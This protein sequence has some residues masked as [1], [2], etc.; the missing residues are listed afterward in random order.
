VFFAKWDNLVLHNYEVLFAKEKDIGYVTK[1]LT[2]L[3]NLK[4]F[5]ASVKINERK[6]G[7]MSIDFAGNTLTKVNAFL[8]VYRTE[9]F[10]RKYW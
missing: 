6:K 8:N 1:D 10:S 4:I 5:S 3:T 2:Q 7:L 9:P